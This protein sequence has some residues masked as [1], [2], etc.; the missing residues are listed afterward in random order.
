MNEFADLNINMAAAK[1]NVFI[2]DPLRNNTEQGLDR[3]KVHLR[4]HMCAGSN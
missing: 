4:V 3:E 1:D 2:F